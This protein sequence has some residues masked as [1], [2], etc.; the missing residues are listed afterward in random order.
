MSPSNFP[1]GLQSLLSGDTNVFDVSEVRHAEQFIHPFERHAFGLRNEKD[2]PDRHGKTETSEEE[3][4]AVAVGADGVQHGRRGSRN[5]EVEQP[6][7]GRG[8]SDVVSS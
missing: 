3:V 1:F 2:D 7:S 8:Q 5:H 4:S 6:L